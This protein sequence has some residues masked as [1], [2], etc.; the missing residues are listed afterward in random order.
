MEFFQRLRAHPFLASTT[1][2]YIGESNTGHV[3]GWTAFEV[4]RQIPNSYAVQERADRNP[5]VF[6]TF[7][8]REEQLSWLVRSVDGRSIG[9]AMDMVVVGVRTETEAVEKRAVIIKECASEL[10]SL[11]RVQHRNPAGVPTTIGWSGKYDAAGRQRNDKFD[12]LVDSLAIAGS[13]GEQFQH[14]NGLYYPRDL[15]GE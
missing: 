1:I 3:S 4:G 9:F 2:V 11:R 15:F 5:G 12:D 14:K 6:T 10:K 13:I 8:S 7:N